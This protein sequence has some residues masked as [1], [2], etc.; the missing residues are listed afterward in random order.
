MLL[1]GRKSVATLMRSQ[2]KCVTG[3]YRIEESPVHL[4]VSVQRYDRW[5]EREC[6]H[7]QL[8]LMETQNKVNKHIKFIRQRLASVDSTYGTQL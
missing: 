8:H 7:K 1:W 6:R 3:T 5:T 2:Q 4:Q